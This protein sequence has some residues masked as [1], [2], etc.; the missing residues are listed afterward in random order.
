MIFRQIWVLIAI[1]LLLTG[2]GIRQ[3]AVAA[4]GALVLLTGGGARLWS[5]LAPERLTYRR[6]LQH[7]RAFVGEEIEV[8]FQIS[9]RKVLPLPWIEVRES[10]PDSLPARDAHATP[11][12]MQGVVYITRSTSL[13]WYER[14]R[15]QHRFYC[16]GRGYVHFGPARLRTGDIFGLFPTE[17][18]DEHFDHLTILPRLVDLPELGLPAER[19]FGDARSGSRLFEDPSRIAGVRDYRQGDP[20]KRIDWKAT[21][22]RQELQ[23]RVYEPSSSLHLLI[24]L[25]VNT[26]EHAWEGYDPV[27]LERSITAAASVARWADEHRFALGLIANSSFPGADRPL[28]IASARDPEQLTRILEALAMVSP[29]TIAPLGDVLEDAARRLPL[30]ATIV[31]IAAFLPERLAARVDRLHRR[32]HPITL[33]WAGDAPPPNLP[34][35]RLYTISDPMRALERTWAAE[36]PPTGIHARPPAPAAV[37]ARQSDDPALRWG[38]PGD[39]NGRQ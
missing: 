34:G 10:A 12:G 20:L 4:V 22:R 18:D 3:P 24:A 38:R 35:V 23:S 31:V 28:G 16:R 33:L 37:A 30:G 11:S 14:V 19:P 1:L 25:N 6:T 2:I 15:W 29:F 26:L 39:G 21:A 13:A 17:V 27:L 9:N 5:R 7:R 36:A 32:G 8:E